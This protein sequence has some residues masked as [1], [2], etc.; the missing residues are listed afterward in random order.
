[1]KKLKILVVLLSIIIILV[2][3]I[4][5][6]YAD[7]LLLGDTNLNNELDIVDATLIQR[8]LADLSNLNEQQIYVADADDDGY[9]AIIDATIVQKCIAKIISPKYRDLDDNGALNLPFVPIK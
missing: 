1:M 5:T 3:S 8:K 9:L 2:S 6:S 7:V 4:I